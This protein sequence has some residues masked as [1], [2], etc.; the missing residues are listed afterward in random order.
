[1][2]D[3]VHI[4][5]GMIVLNGEPFT[6][7]N[8]RSLYPYAHQII[9]VEGACPGA[10]NIA[11]PDG[12]SRDGTLEILRRFQAEEDPEH[13][14][15]VVT[16]E[17]EGHP[18]G[19][20]TEKDEMSQAYAKRATGNYLW[21]VDSDEFYRA[22]DIQS[23]IAML[24]DNP[25]IDGMSFKQISFW[26]GFDY[27]VDAYYLRS[28]PEIC[29]RLF[30]W[31]DGYTY[32]IHRPPTVHD[33]G[34][35]NLRD[36]DY[37]SGYDLAKKG[38]VMYHYSL[39]LPK[40]VIEKC[41]YYSSVDWIDRKRATQ[42]ADDVFFGLRRPYRVHNVYDQPGWLLRFN[43][44]H[45]D[46]ALKMRD[47]IVAGQ[48]SVDL[49]PV[50]DIERLLGSPLYRGGIAVLKLLHPIYRIIQPPAAK[51]NR[52]FRKLIASPSTVIAQVRDRLR[53]PGSP[54]G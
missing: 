53:K 40:Q 15:V 8:L 39:L 14:V 46:Q 22:E 9:V 21:Q 23:S 13:K 12:H 41:D 26:G 36:L 49:R 25:D 54:E 28:G 24:R 2:S 29:H 42:W 5:F 34:G 47:D 6:R 44:S 4:T 7:Y 31:G 10:R 27:L 16:G 50:D 43:G 19:F 35:R 1:M 32:V 11:T 45:P 51:W 33:A 20:W 52:R 3:S 30:R 17:D 38:I 48:V 37:I 18:D